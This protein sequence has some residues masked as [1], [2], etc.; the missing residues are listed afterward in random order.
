MDLLPNEPVLALERFTLKREPKG[1]EPVIRIVGRQSGLMGWI[2]SL[3]RLDPV[4]ELVVT[5]RDITFTSSSLFGRCTEVVPLTS[6]AS[7]GSGI[8]KPMHFLL[9]ALVFFL[10]LAGYGLFGS[11]SAVVWVIAGLVVGGVFKLA[12]ALG[13]RFALSV[14]TTGATSFG[15]A[16]KRGAIDGTALDPDL[17]DRAARV[18]RDL[19]IAAAGGS[20]VAAPEPAKEEAEI[21]EEATTES[22][23]VQEEE[24]AAVPPPLPPPVPSVA[25]REE[26]VPEEPAEDEKAEEEKAEEELVEPPPPPVEE[27]VEEEP[28]PEEPAEEELVEPPPPPV[29]EKIEE[30]PAS[31][32][33]AEEETIEPPP[34]PV[35]EKVE[36]P[37]P[38]APPEEPEPQFPMTQTIQL[39]AID[40]SQLPPGD[41]TLME[42]TTELPPD[43]PDDDDVEE[44]E[45]QPPSHIR[46]KCPKCSRVLRIKPEYFGRKVRCPICQERFI[47]GKD[48]SY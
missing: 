28:A 36:L 12:Y 32:E 41:S 22:V 23:V 26:P 37:P 31:E 35:E 17:A 27:R 43:L 48:G 15:I 40:P 5:E 18:I 9:L 33:P 39:R 8:K 16:F 1:A 13:K 4:T 2:L 44:E 38:P 45:E 47:L 29:E 7:A 14:T 6:V 25:D 46:G 24:T 3:M 34:P 20:R 10:A 21:L 30:E 19:C 42:K 11:D